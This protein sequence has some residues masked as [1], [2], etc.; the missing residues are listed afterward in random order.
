MKFLASFLI[1]SAVFNSAISFS[2]NLTKISGTI[3][4]QENQGVDLA[5][6]WIQNLSDSA[7]V[8]SDYSDTDGSFLLPKIGN[9]S[10][11]LNVQ[12]LGYVKH[13]STISVVES[14]PTL[15]LDPIKL[16][17]SATDLEAFEVSRKV[18]Y[19][20]RKL[21]RIVVNVGS[22][23]AN[24]GGDV[25]EAMERAP[26][27]TVDN[28]GNILLKGRSGVSVFI[29][30]KPSYLSGTDL[31]N[32][33]KSLPAGTVQSIEIME[34]PPAKYDAAGSA[35]VINIVLKR[36]QLKGINGNLSV[37]YRQGRYGN[38]NNSLNLNYNHK[39]IGVYGNL[40][41]GYWNSYQDLNINRRFVNEAGET[42][43]SFSQ[44]SFGQNNG[45][46]WNGTFGVDFFPSDKTTFGLSFKN[47]KNPSQR[48]IDNTA[49]VGD[50][51]G[52]LMQRVVADNLTD[53]NF[54][55]QVWS[56]S[57]NHK[58]DSIGSELTLNGDKVSYHSD[59][60]QKF[61]NFIY[62]SND[63]LEFEDQI[64]GDLPS[65]IDIYALKTDFTKALGKG[66]FEAGAKMA[67]S[68]TDNEAIYSTTFNGTTSPNY[69][70][71][72]RFV[73]DEWINAAYVN[74]TQ[75]LGRVSIQAGLR[76]ENTIMEGDQ[77]GNV[78]RKDTSFTRK[79]TN[80]FPTF[81]TSW[82][83]DSLSK[84]ILTF[85]YGRRINRPFFQDLNPFISP[86]DKFTFY[87]GNP[88]LLPTFSHN[89]SLAHTFHNAVT[90][91]AN[92]SKTL[93]G[94]N[95]T[96]EIRDSIY[97]SRPGNIAN[98]TSKGISIQASLPLAD[99][100]SLNTY[101]EATHNSFDSP[102]YD[103]QLESEG[104]FYFVQASNSFSFN[105]GWSADLTGSY[106]S[107]LVYA[108]LLIKSY[109]QIG[110]GIKK[111]LLD[112]A[113][114]LKV[115]VSDLFKTRRG[116]GIINNLSQTKADWNSTFD[117]RRV[118]LAFSYR[119]GTSSRKGRRNR[120]SGSQEEQTRIK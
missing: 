32:Y 51:S 60:E 25:M 112:G 3:V 103:Q 30:D 22:L 109:G 78:V 43:S 67:F 10:Y 66:K 52:Q 53:R 81:Y 101:M 86:L 63:S 5:L 87:S 46:Y 27:V 6:V 35:G 40:A 113:G 4:D 19:V 79:Y 75:S 37:G 62:S 120:Q 29:N 72:N 59:A 108:Q 104:M 15:I 88:D 94:I 106:Q 48:L 54:E 74:L 50:A 96:L 73:Y 68:S 107:N 9:G 105:K 114:S 116:D 39:K 85:S 117:S 7:I 23:I 90:I 33:L 61:M 98:S 84:H 20:E 64:N 95:E 91:T 55:N 115:S 76:V 102:L 80:A 65:H 26:G 70:L 93:D 31:E 71:S 38:N 24:E 14:Q 42:N 34:N 21:D 110:F 16:L 89:F 99:W 45:K 118:G 83:M 1:F 2:Q 44:N 47:N 49:L 56:F 8:K 12:M 58:L 77:K 111:N 82:Q 97:Y 100:Y 57:F 92:Y 13:Q 36:N 69:E 11:I 17:P 28:D 18:G 119:F 41:A